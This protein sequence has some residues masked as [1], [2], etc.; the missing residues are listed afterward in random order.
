[1]TILTRL[2]DTSQRRF[3]KHSKPGKPMVLDFGHPAVTEGRTLFTR[4]ANAGRGT[5]RVLISALNQRKI[6]RRIT[7]GAWAGFEVYTLTLEERKTCPRSCTEW[8]S[9]YGNHMPWSIR[10]PHGPGLETKL[11]N[12]LM[13]LQIKHPKGFVV[14]LHILG[15]F[16]SV[17]YVQRWIYWLDAFPALHVFGYTARSY[18]DP[19]GIAVRD[20]AKARW[21]RFAVRSSGRALG[22]HPAAVVVETEDQAKRE[23]AILCPAQT[24]KTSCCATCALCWSTTKTIAFQRH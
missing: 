1:M 13:Q 11:E 8:R 5:G 3:T 4:S 16:Y 6:G 24:D 12:E 14:R 23:E 9:C 18:K 19:I 21:D 10:A 7:K 15:D 2:A 22:A 17:S 20:L